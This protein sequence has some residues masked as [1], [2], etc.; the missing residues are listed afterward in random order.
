MCARLTGFHNMASF[1]H[2]PLG[3]RLRTTKRSCTMRTLDVVKITKGQL[4]DIME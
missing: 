3:K 1:L 4:I 2:D